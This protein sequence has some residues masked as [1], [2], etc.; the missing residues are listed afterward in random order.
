MY[1]IS[2]RC[3]SSLHT[4]VRNIPQVS[5]QLLQSV[6]KEQDRSKDSIPWHAVHHLVGEI[7]YGGK[8][9]NAQDMRTLRALLYRNC[10]SQSITQGY[11]N[12]KVCVCV[13]VCACVCVCVCETSL[14]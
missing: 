1:V 13:C 11:R 9:T 5:V 3:Q 10:S 2:L 14:G 7:C 8:V 12:I 6:F 4:Y